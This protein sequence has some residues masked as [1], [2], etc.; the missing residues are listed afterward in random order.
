MHLVLSRVQEDDFDELLEVQFRAFAH[1]DMHTAIMGKNTLEMRAL[2]KE[3]FVKDMREDPT[4]C[5]MKLVDTATGK[6]VSAAQWKIYS[7]WAPLASHGEFKADWFEGKEREAAEEMFTKFMTIRSGHMYGHSHV[8]LYILF[9]D[10]NFQRCGAGS[11]HVKWGTELADRLLVPCWVEGS[12]DGYHLYEENGFK[13]V[14]YVNEK[15]GDWLLE[16][17]VMKRE[18]KTQY[19]AGRSIV[20]T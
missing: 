20:F 14:Q 11:I 16:Y 9:T 1:L 10:P 12:P 4:D 3:K 15:F 17:T 2:A 6:I 7:T 5:W 18:S 19:E 8:L 13:D